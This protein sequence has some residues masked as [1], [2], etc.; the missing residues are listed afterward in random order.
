MSQK[1]I[2]TSPSAALRIRGVSRRFGAVVALNAVDLDVPAGRFITL[3]GPSGCGKTTLLRIIAGLDVA[4]AGSVMLGDLKLDELPAHRRPVNTVF[5]NYALFPHLDVFENIAFGLRSR[6]FSES[7]IH[8]RVEDAVELLHLRELVRRQS[9]E[10]SGGQKQRVALARALVNRPQVLLLDEPMSALDAKLRTEL[11]VELRHLQRKLGTTFILVTHDQD[12]AMTVSDEIVVLRQGGIEQQ[13][14]PMDIYEHP[15]NR[16]VATF[17]GAATLIDA[18]R[19]ADDAM[20][21]STAFGRLR[22]AQA[23]PWQRGTL[24]IRPERVKLC[25]EA[26]KQTP[27]PEA[28]GVPP[29]FSTRP[30]KL[31]AENRVCV[32]ITD[33]VYRGDHIEARAD[34]GGLRLRAPAGTSLSPG[35]QVQCVLPAE[36]LE[37]LRD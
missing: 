35:Q 22:L 26:A 13:G 31:E 12:E 15:A 3:L 27:T 17:L 37:A 30:T 11:Q 2:A 23:P 34:P 25:D 28:A 9:H 14:P 4:D 16:F 10:L 33:C 29:T 24:A 8:Q 6:R 18:T 21:V 1:S 5:Q 36:N 19:E 20:C 32:T 7:D